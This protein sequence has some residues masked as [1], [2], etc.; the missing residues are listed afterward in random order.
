MAPPRFSPFCVFN[1]FYYLLSI[2]TTLVLF[3]SNPISSCP[4]RPCLPLSITSYFCHV[5]LFSVSCSF[6]IDLHT[7]SVGLFHVRV[8]DPF[9]SS[10]TCGPSNNNISTH[11]FTYGPAGIRRQMQSLKQCRSLPAG[12]IVR[13]DFIFRH[14]RSS[15]G[16]RWTCQHEPN[17]KLSVCLRPDFQSSAQPSKK[18]S[19]FSSDI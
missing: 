11:A 13:N 14:C 1:I 15:F 12:L 4:H 16:V 18:D 7:H 9:T 8:V 17:F 2:S 5:L 10:C 3:I 6:D 19:C